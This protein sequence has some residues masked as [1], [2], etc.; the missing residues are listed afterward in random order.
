M[1]QFQNMRKYVTPEIIFGSGARHVVGKY[2][3]QFM[4]SNVMLV[5]DK[6]V[7]TTPWFLDVQKSLDDAGILYQSFTDVSPNPRAE[8]VMVG[9]ELYNQQGCDVIVAVGGGSPMD[10]A[11]A[12]GM[13]SSNRQNILNFEGVDR[14]SLP[15][16]PL[17]FVPTTAGSSA[18]VSQFCIITNRQ[19]LKK[20]AIVSKAIV[21][22]VALIDPETTLSADH[23]L[24]ACCGVDALTHA[25][26]AFVSTGSGVLTDASALEAIK[27]IHQYLPA[28]LQAPDNLDLREKI[29]LGSMKAGLAFSNASLGAVHAMAHSLGGTLDLAHGECNAMLLDHVVAFNYDASPERFKVI[30]EALSMDIRGLNSAELKK[31]LMA[32]I[33]AFKV[34]VGIA[35]Q[36]NQKGV[37][38]SDVPVLSGKALTDACMLT[39]PRKASKRDVEVIFEEAM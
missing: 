30:S 1:N 33:S 24:T 20:I 23:F 17:I 36:L 38:S 37:S 13:V 10:C 9:A 35:N 4:A 26:E 27:L 34:T 3:Q 19:A 21:P 18:D 14:I 11:K 25:I 15:V 32:E 12:I 22:D 6:V 7:A 8:E 39:N 31:A 16:P 2:A 29:M 5:S 28:L